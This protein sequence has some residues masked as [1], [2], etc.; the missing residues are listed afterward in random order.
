MV[1]RSGDRHL[2]GGRGQGVLL[3]LL[4]ATLLCPAKP[5]PAIASASGQAIT[6]ADSTLRQLFD[7]GTPYPKFLANARARRELR[8]IGSDIG[9]AIMNAHR[10]PDGRAA[11]PTVLL[12]DANFTEIVE[13]MERGARHTR[14]R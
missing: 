10:T 7:R 4:T 8:I 3:S 2:N 9:R 12:L 11:T 5:T 6:A 14:I 1:L 13:L